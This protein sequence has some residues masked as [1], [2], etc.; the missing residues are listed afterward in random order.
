M[1]SKELMIEFGEVQQEVVTKFPHSHAL[2]VTQRKGHL[3]YTSFN[4]SML[5]SKTLLKFNG[6]K[7]NSN[8]LRH[9]FITAYRDYLMHPSTAHHRET[10]VNAIQGAAA[11][12][13][14]SPGVWDH[15]DDVTGDRKMAMAMAHWPHFQA[16]MRKK[17]ETYMSREDIDPLTFDFSSLRE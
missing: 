4:F 17:D 9:L 3:P 1:L 14:N 13:Q 8:G 6:K 15:Y 12:M 7:I 2:F 10:V 11:M 5:I 16:F